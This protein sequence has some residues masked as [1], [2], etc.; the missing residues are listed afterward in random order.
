MYSRLKSV[1]D[2]VASIVKFDVEPSNINTPEA[3]LKI[4]QAIVS[5]DWKTHD[6]VNHGVSPRKALGVF[7]NSHHGIEGLIAFLRKQING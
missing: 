4:R 2:F 6:L 5:R 3:A 7:L 1:D